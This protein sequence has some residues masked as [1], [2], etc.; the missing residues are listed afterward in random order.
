MSHIG[1]A[2]AR[3]RSARG[4]AH[5]QRE[6]KVVRRPMASAA[7]CN[8]KGGLAHTDARPAKISPR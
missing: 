4:V 5:L 6:K 2:S 8:T 3:M 1:N 7:Q